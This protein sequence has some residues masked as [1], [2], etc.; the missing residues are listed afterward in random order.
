[1][2]GEGRKNKMKRRRK[3]RSGKRREKIS[4]KSKRLGSS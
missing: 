4:K 1:M 3:V 2:W